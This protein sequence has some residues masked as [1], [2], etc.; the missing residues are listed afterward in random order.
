M[1]ESDEDSH[2]AKKQRI[3]RD[4]LQKE[5]AVLQATKDAIGKERDYLAK[6]HEHLM[7]KVATIQNTLNASKEENALKKEYDIKVFEIQ[8]KFDKEL[9]NLKMRLEER[10]LV[11]K[12]EIFQVKQEAER[13]EFELIL[14]HKEE[15]FELENKTVK[16]E[17][18]PNV[19]TGGAHMRKRSLLSALVDDE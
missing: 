3:Q 5:I 1:P 18:S 6:Q 11:L 2:I 17:G 4:D 19:T 9:F 10:E 15:M 14:K 12:R 13:R 16:P 8:E 7:R